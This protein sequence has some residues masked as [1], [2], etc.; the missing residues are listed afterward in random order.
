MNK[1]MV[2]VWLVTMVLMPCCLFAQRSTV[3]AI[4]QLG[5]HKSPH[6]INEAFLLHQEGDA[7]GL[8]FDRKQTTI[9]NDVT[10]IAWMSDSLLVYSVSPVGGKPGIYRYDYR[11]HKSEFVLK[12]TSFDSAYPDGADFFELHSIDM[13]QKQVFFYYGSHVDSID[14]RDFRSPKYLLK[15][16]LDGSGLTKVND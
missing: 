12:P 4:D 11:T 1:N 6:R 3:T 14:F 10:G 8:A 2:S 9:V 5:R 15:V 7:L 13:K 16:N